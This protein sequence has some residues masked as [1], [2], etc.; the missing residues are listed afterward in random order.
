MISN[1]LKKKSFLRD[2]STNCKNFQICPQEFARMP[3]MA[4]AS[5]A[6]VKEEK[7]EVDEQ[8]AQKEEPKDLNAIAIESGSYDLFLIKQKDPILN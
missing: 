6:E 3:P 8:P 7:M 1:K 4:A 2:F 5:S